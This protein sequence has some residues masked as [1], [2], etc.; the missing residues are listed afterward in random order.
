MP[1]INKIF[2]HSNLVVKKFKCRGRR[3]TGFVYENDTK[4]LKRKDSI[5]SYIEIVD[6]EILQKE[7]RK[8]RNLSKLAAVFC[9]FIFDL[10]NKFI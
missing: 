5:E 1:L 10:K 3:G 4:F 2:G 8:A 6:D 7:A 9:R